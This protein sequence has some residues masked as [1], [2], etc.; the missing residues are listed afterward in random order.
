VN[1]TGKMAIPATYDDVNSFNEGLA[2]VKL[3]EKWGY[4]DKLGKIVIPLKY[5]K[6]KSFNCGLAAV[7]KSTERYDLFGYIDKTGKV[8]IPFQFIEA[9]NFRYGIIDNSA[10]VMDTINYESFLI[11][12]K[13]TSIT[14]GYNGMAWTENSNII[15]RVYD[16]P[17]RLGVITSMDDIIVPIEFKEV[18]LIPNDYRFLVSDFNDKKGVYDFK[19]PIIPVIYD[20][21]I[22]KD[23]LFFVNI[24]GVVSN[25]SI[26]GGKNGIYNYEGE[27][28]TEVIYDY[29]GAFVDNVAV[30]IRNGKMGFINKQGKEIV[31]PLYDYIFE[32][33]FFEGLAAVNIGGISDPQYGFQGGKWGF[34]DKSGKIVIDL[35][36][37][38]ALV[39]NEGVVSVKRGD[40]VGA[41]DAS[42]KT[43]ISFDY[44]DIGVFTEGVAYFVKDNLYG[45][46]DKTGKVI[47]NNT[48]QYAGGFNDGLAM[49]AKDNKV[50]YINKT[51][52]IVI[53]IQY[54]NGDI[55]IDGYAIVVKNQQKLFD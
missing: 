4:I 52:E 30:V 54:D 36:Y 35:I 44:Q 25:N 24:G 28:I 39:F 29:I 17:K 55:F 27:R 11:N 38:A 34:I 32:G 37:D 23:S 47:I 1:K 51:G 15:V 3:N 43:I 18:A 13:G 2:S 40:M 12:D 10:I 21:I 7:L 49:V 16:E 9:S 31:E 42:G 5:D 41:I 6:A 53:P 22:P 45:F 26:N 14:K 46:I 20:F 50:G 48:F 19:N 33:M 8:V